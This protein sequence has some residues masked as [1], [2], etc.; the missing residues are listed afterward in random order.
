MKKLFVSYE[1]ALVA[2]E[3]GFD[4]SCFTWY[5]KSS[6]KLAYGA[7]H[8]DGISNPILLAIRLTEKRVAAPIYQQLVDWFREKYF[9]HITVSPICTVNEV[10]GMVG[11]INFMIN[12]FQRADVVVDGDFDYYETLNMILLEAFKLIPW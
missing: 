9:M 4:K 5:Y 1:L 12:A 6:K 2:K 3:K 10:I 7:Y 11:R 8:P